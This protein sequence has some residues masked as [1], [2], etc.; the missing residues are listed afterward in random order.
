MSRR[1]SERTT[2]SQATKLFYVSGST[3]SIN[4]LISPLRFGQLQLPG[5]S[6]SSP[7]SVKLFTPTTTPPQARNGVL[8][9]TYNAASDPSFSEMFSGSYDYQQSGLSLIV[10][11][12]VSSEDPSADEKTNIEDGRRFAEALNADF[13]KV[14]TSSFPLQTNS[15]MTRLYRLIAERAQLI[16]R[17]R[18]LDPMVINHRPESES[19]SQASATDESIDSLPLTPH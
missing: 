7:Y 12:F 3:D 18:F 16:P 1:Q 19:E 5:E 17:V 9:I 8:V 14:K 11:G 6:T 4:R 10:V 15:E 13:F 2:T